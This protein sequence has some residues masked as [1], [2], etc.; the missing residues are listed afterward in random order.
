MER[1]IE[2]KR[3]IAIPVLLAL[4]VLAAIPTL[5]MA[6]PPSDVLPSH[7]AAPDYAIPYPAA[8]L[9]PDP[10][11]LASATH[12]GSYA[13]PYPPVDLDGYGQ[14]CLASGTM[15]P[16]RASASHM[17]IRY[18]PANPDGDSGTH[19]VRYAIPYP[20]ANPDGDSGTHI[21]RYAIPYPSADLDGDGYTSFAR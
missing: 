9:D 11:Y 2:M 1:G 16:L 7:C 15:H 18:Q 13:I 17:V 12:L 6:A 14:E 20:S 3:R 21:V 4:L 10:M 8:S 5:G 19:G